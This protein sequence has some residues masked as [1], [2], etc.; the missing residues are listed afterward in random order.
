MPDHVGAV[1]FRGKE[2]RGPVTLR[3][4]HLQPDAA[5]R[6][7]LAFGVHRAGTRDGLPAGKLLS[8][9]LVDQTERVHHARGRAADVV[10]VHGHLHTGHV[11]TVRLEEPLRGR[12]RGVLR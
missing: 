6:A 3:A 12:G 1:G 4:D 7:N 11:I 9:H 8:G 2:P 10:D 5:D